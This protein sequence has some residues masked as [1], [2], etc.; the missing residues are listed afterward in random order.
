MDSIFVSGLW[1]MVSGLLLQDFG[2]WIWELG[3]WL[4]WIKDLDFYDVMNL[5]MICLL[6]SR[7]TFLCLKETGHALDTCTV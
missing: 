2:L 3:F 7:M 5:D 4:L 1:F 6:F